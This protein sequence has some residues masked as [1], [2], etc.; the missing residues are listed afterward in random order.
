MGKN[1]IF[2][3]F[4]S[5]GI[6]KYKILIKQLKKLTKNK[7]NQKSRQ[8]KELKNH[9]QAKVVLSASTF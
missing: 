5:S 2:G 6:K 1:Y 4:L 9:H 8:L 7:K 3:F